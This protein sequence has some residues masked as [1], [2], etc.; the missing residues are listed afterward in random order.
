MSFHGGL[1]GVVISS[2]TTF[3][4]ENNTK[5]FIFL[6]FSFFSLLLLG[7]FLGGLAN[8]INS[9]LYGRP[10]ESPMGSKI[11]N[12]IDNIDRHPSQ[13]YE[14]FFEGIILFYNA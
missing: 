3:Q 4:K 14:A 6:R 11:Y 13:L 9:E 2:S 1:I 10:T 7:F 8:F 5:P 12:L